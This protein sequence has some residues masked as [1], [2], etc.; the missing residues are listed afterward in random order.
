MSTYRYW[1]NITNKFIEYSKRNFIVYGIP[2]WHEQTGTINVICIRNND[3]NS[4]NDAIRNNDKL[5][6]IEN[7]PNDSFR[8]YE[9][10]VTADP[11]AKKSG[12][13][14]VSEGAYNSYVVRPH[15]W[16]AGRTALCQDAGEVRIFRTYS[17]GKL[18][19][20]EWGYFGINVHDTGGFWNSSLG[21]VIL[22]DSKQYQNEFKPLLLR[23]KDVHKKL[24]LNFSL[25]VINHKTL[26][27]L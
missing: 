10:S 26:K 12:I 18:M 6:I 17:I 27:R 19:H 8:L 5:V 1:Q 20:Y 23:A 13:A 21:C 3:E 4:F 2:E 22:A 24:N 14:H 25:F 9:Y 15:R 7:R 11:S 16:I